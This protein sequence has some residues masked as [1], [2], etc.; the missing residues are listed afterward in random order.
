M[1]VL[2]VGGTGFIGRHLTKALQSNGHKVRILSRSVSHAKLSEE[3]EYFCGD[4]LDVD[5]LCGALSGIDVCVHA[6]TSTIPS[7]AA[8]NIE[9]D[10]STNLLGS[11]NLMRACV[12]QG[13]KRLVFL[14]SGGTIYGVPKYHPISEDHPTDPISAY[15]IVKL[16]IEKYLEYFNHSY[17]L[18][19]A[20]TRLSNP[21][22]TGQA[23][24]RQQGIIPIFINRVLN[25][26][27]LEVFGD[28]EAVRDYIYIDDAV[29]GV[30]TLIEGAAPHKI[31]NIGS[32]VGSSINDIITA[33][34]AATGLTAKVSYRPA[35]AFDVNINILDCRRAKIDLGWQASESLSEGILKLAKWYQSHYP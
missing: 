32:G 4:L 6:A 18:D 14:S 21:Y 5:G 13:V 7:T 3:A 25:G 1:Y 30:L 17:G 34:N 28:G 9:F 26:L 35:R 19:Y 8:D 29:G 23:L 2:L 16:S 27:P 22:G 12:T 33:I 15:G 24:N 11:I 31:Y 10:I 20:V